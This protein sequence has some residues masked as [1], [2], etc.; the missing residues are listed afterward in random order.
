MLAAEVKEILRKK[1]ALSEGVQLLYSPEDGV[2]VQAAGLL[3]ESM[4]D[5]GMRMCSYVALV[6][7]CAD[8]VCARS[9]EP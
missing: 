8:S 1:K 3:F 7:V 6:N 9:C 5:N 2:K 4:K